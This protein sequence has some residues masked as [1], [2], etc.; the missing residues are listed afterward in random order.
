MFLF[1]AEEDLVS[2]EMTDQRQEVMDLFV[3]TKEWQEVKEGKF[4]SFCFI[5]GRISSLG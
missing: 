5:A 4:N 2:P 3:P 1:F